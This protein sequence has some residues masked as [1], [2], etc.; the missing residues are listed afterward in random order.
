VNEIVKLIRG[1]YSCGVKRCLSSAVVASEHVFA[2]NFVNIARICGDT[3]NSPAGILN[4][5]GHIREA[6][7]QILM[8]EINKSVTGVKRCHANNVKE[9]YQR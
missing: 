5:V 7:H 2:S 9:I 8:H 6:L 4:I 3:L 1:A